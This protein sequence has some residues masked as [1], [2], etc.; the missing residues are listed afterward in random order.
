MSDR[1][2]LYR[3]NSSYNHKSSNQIFLLAFLFLWLHVLRC[4]LHGWMQHS[5]FAGFN[6]WHI[7]VKY[8]PDFYLTE[9]ATDKETS[10]IWFFLFRNA[11]LHESFIIKTLILSAGL[12]TYEL[13][14]LYSLLVVLQ[15]VSSKGTSC[16][17]Y[18]TETALTNKRTF[19]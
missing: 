15:F 2:F 14:L 18:R 10:F 6:K 12:Y 1:L 19:S 11:W 13:I 4:D 8:Y 5:N 9:Q 16:G 17:F 3:F 7:T